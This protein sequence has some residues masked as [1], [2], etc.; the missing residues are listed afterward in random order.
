M[1]GGIASKTLA[2]PIVDQKPIVDADFDVVVEGMTDDDPANAIPGIT[3]EGTIEVPLPD[4]SV[5]IDLNPQP[6]RAQKATGHDENLVDKIGLGELSRICGDLCQA[7]ESDDGSRS[8]WLETRARGIELLGLKLND[9]KSDIASGAPLEGMSTVRDPI[10]LEA[11]IRFMANASAELLPAAGPVKVK[12]I[13]AHTQEADKQAETLERDMNGYLT[14]VASDY[15][16]DTTRMLFMT[17]FGGS[18][19]KKIYHSPLKNRPVSEY[20]DA[21]DLIVSNAAVDLSSASRVTHVVRMKPSDMIR[22][23][24]LGV[25]SDIETSGQPNAPDRVQQA[26]NQTSGITPPQD[27]VEDQ[28]YELWECYCELNIDG[29]EHKKH[30]KETGLPLPYR[31]TID[32]NAQQILEISRNWDEGDDEYRPRH[33][34]VEYHYIKGFGFYGIGLLHILGNIATALTAGTREVLDAGML[35]NFPG[36]LYLKDGTRQMTNNFRVPPGG[37]APVQGG[38]GRRIQDLVMALPYK[39]PGPAFMQF[40]DSLRQNG[41]AVGGINE[42]SVGEGRQ[43]APVGTTLALIEQATKVEGAVHKGLHASQSEELRLLKQLFEED[44]EAL[45]RHARRTEGKWNE[46]ALREALANVDLIPQADPN[47]PSHMQRMMRALGIKQLQAANPGLY[48][49][50]KVDARVL[51]ML[52]IDDFDDLFLPPQPPSQLPP[53][54]RLL[55]A[56]LNA[57]IKQAELGAKMQDSERDRQLKLAIEH[58]KRQPNPADPSAPVEQAPAID[59]KLAVALINAENARLERE[60]DAEQKERDRDTKLMIEKLK[61]AGNLAVHPESEALV[62]SFLDTDKVPLYRN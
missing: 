28:D 14:T 51:Q 36:F 32:K 46:T 18:G 11:C 30:G 6:S 13:G 37:G 50:R 8:Q 49:P 1:A 2:T 57:Q 15:Y 54:P 24:L 53:D 5:I 19:F 12:N 52:G 17:G 55:V 23:K 43:D 7:I 47:T 9:P 31:V 42:I 58:L 56:Q 33:L 41:R 3:E 20:V 40:L 45:W 38:D 27:R 39:E 44:P 16:P 34:F 4:G 25:Y 26:I 35:A 29:F 61:L 48:D 60:A 22:M 21:K 59:P 10:L 62:E